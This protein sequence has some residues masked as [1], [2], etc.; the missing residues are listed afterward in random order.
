MADILHEFHRRRADISYYP[1]VGSGPNSCVLHYRDNSRQ[2][3][4]GELLLIDAGCEF[5]YYASDVTRTL[6]VGGRYGRR[7]RAVYEVVLE[8]QRAAIA[9]VRRARTG[10]NR[11]RRPCARSRKA[12]CASGS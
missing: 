4:E 2:M 10:T 9:K 5:D 12:W 6:P 1:I 7:Q 3:Q 11:T 8:A